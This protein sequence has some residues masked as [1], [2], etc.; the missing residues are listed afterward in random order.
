MTCIA[1]CSLSAHNGMLRWLS[2]LLEHPLCGKLV[3]TKL[4]L[5]IQHSAHSL[6]SK[7]STP[8]LICPKTSH[9]GCLHKNIFASTLCSEH[10]QAL[11]DSSPTVAYNTQHKCATHMKQLICGAA[12]EASYAACHTPILF[13]SGVLHKLGMFSFKECPP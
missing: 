3:K 10:S 4:R 5:A 8:Q 13:S 7:L 6:L 9:S 2:C 11:A 1:L 12:M